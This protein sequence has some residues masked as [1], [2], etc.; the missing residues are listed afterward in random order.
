MPSWPILSVFGWPLLGTGYSTT[1][2][3]GRCN[4]SRLARASQYQI[5]PSR[6]TS[7]PSARLSVVG[8]GN[9]VTVGPC[10]AQAGDSK[11]AIPSPMI[12][13]T[14][15]IGFIP[16][17]FQCLRQRHALV[18]IAVQIRAVERHIGGS[19][20]SER[21][22]AR[23]IDLPLAARGERLEGRRELEGVV[24]HR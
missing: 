22:L 23:A 15:K 20:R 17:S 3:S 10:F 8:V 5:E 11:S 6:A 19:A 14:K 13:R 21:V 9:S 7:T 12:H 18:E 24:H 4:T 1:L 16:V 2:R